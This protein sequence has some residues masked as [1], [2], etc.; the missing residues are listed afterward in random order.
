MKREIFDAFFLK[1]FSRDF[2][3][4][5]LTRHRKNKKSNQF[6][7]YL[8]NYLLLDETTRRRS[9]VDN[10]RNRM[11][12]ELGWTRA[13]AFNPR[14]GQGWTYPSRPSGS[15]G[16]E[17][18]SGRITRARTFVRRIESNRHTCSSNAQPEFRLIQEARVER[19]TLGLTIKFCPTGWTEQAILFEP[20]LWASSGVLILRLGFEFCSSGWIGL[21]KSVRTQL[22]DHTRQKFKLQVAC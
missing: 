1:K 18:L 19:P 13:R 10:D 22:D 3:S 17:F 20:E 8:R 21:K 9:L 11:T 12:V 4:L 2:L 6:S 15:D 5:I 7:I 14:F 16:L